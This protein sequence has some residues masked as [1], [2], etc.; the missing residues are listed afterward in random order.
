M[1]IPTLILAIISLLIVKL[2]DISG[3]EQKRRE[4]DLNNNFSKT[5]RI[6]Y[7]FSFF[8]VMTGIAMLTIAALAE[9]NII[10]LEIA[11]WEEAMG[12]IMI[13]IFIFAVMIENE[14]FSV[15]GKIMFLTCCLVMV[16]IL[17]TD[18]I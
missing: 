7:Y 8:T 14:V 15:Y 12:A 16:K 11:I 2:A 3:K 10:I 1:I 9:I 6:C 17:T 13:G 4:A 18:Y 5:E